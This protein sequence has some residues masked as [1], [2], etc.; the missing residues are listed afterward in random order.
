M[1]R[2]MSG[3]PSRSPFRRRDR[4]PSG[5]TAIIP[6][7]NGSPDDGAG[8]TGTEPAAGGSAARPQPG[9]LGEHLRDL[10]VVPSCYLLARVAMLRLLRPGYLRGILSLDR[11]ALPLVGLTW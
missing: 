9:W 6:A 2:P 4:P 1:S 7:V 3:C 10:I 11:Q 5:R 8:G